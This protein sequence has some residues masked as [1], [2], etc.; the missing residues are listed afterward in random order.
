MQPSPVQ[1]VLGSR[2]LRPDIW[3]IKVFFIGKT[4]KNLKKII[5]FS[6]E[7]FQTA[8]PLYV[9]L[10][11]SMSLYGFLCL[12]ASCSGCLC[13]AMFFESRHSQTAGIQRQPVLGSSRQALSAYQADQRA[14]GHH[15]RRTVKQSRPP[16]S[17]TKP[18]QA[19]HE[20]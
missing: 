6:F 7:G 8:V 5:F 13:L 20:A 15:P 18:A 12:S 10:C 2:R 4:M 9:V 1:S 17:A 16:R 19:A 14:R 3:V 11:L